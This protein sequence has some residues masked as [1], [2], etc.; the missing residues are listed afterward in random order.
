M[1]QQIKVADMTPEQKREYQRLAKRRSR[2]K[3]KQKQLASQIPVALDYE[4]PQSQ[5]DELAEH[6]RQIAAT[7]AA[8]LPTSLSFQGEC[9]IEMAS[10]ILFAHERGWTKQVSSP[11]GVLYG[12]FYPDAAGAELIEHFHRF[13]N[14]A[15]SQTF[16][17]LYQRFLTLIHRLSRN[18]WFDPNFAKDIEA[19][20]NGTYTLRPKLAIPQPTP[21]PAPA[22]PQPR[23]PTDQEILE[24]GRIRL[25]EQLQPHLPPEARNYL[26]GN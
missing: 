17:D 20:I 2:E 25:L 24:Q 13:P 4:P 1:E 18:E 10:T 15:E 12:S 8:E 14:L 16:K 6:S 19:E 3:A 7:I 22:P 21:E 23:L 11:Y 9:V 26:N 5:K